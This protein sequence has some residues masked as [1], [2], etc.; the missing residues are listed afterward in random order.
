ME[1]LEI[2][3]QDW[4]A[5]EVFFVELFLWTVSPLPKRLYK[6]A[7]RIHMH[8]C[9]NSSWHWSLLPLFSR[10]NG[11]PAAMTNKLDYSKSMKRWLG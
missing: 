4:D 2:G 3:A 1:L 8:Q 11:N 5:L 7:E 9:R 10:R 6:H